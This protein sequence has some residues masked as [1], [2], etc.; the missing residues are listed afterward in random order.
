[1][2]AIALVFLLAPPL[3]A[4]L[5]PGR[6]LSRER[7]AGAPRAEQGWDALDATTR[8]LVQRLPGR[9]GAVDANTWISRHVFGTT[10]RY[11][12]GTALDAALPFGPQGGQAGYAQSGGAASS[13]PIA[14]IG[15]DG[16]L[17]LQGELDIT[18]KPPID[19]VEATRRWARLVAELRASGR[20]VVLTIVPEKSTVY[21]RFVQPSTISW[22]CARREKARIWQ[23]I[24]AVRDP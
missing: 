15:R 9:S 6:P 7:T 20:H 2:V 24:E 3:L 11:G 14:A 13:H 17:F 21:P 4:L 8:Y 5:R 19:P 23:A 1:M 10:P 18:C 16:W 22:T 12:T